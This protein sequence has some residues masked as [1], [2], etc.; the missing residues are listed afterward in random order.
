MAKKPSDFRLGDLVEIHSIHHNEWIL[1][2]R[3]GIV[4]QAPER[5]STL[6]I[7]QV[8]LDNEEIVPVFG[9]NMFLVQR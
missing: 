8:L 6:D 3:I 4:I 9:R 7:W 2:G 1:S 5:G